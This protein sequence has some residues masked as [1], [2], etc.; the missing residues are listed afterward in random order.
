MI[1]F[2]KTIRQQLVMENKTSKYIKYA[3]GEIV[4][5]VIGIL[6]ALQINT[7]NDQRKQE[8]EEK[9]A[10][11]NIKQDFSYNKK[12]LQEV[13]TDTDEGIQSCLNV[14]KYTGNKP[15]PEREQYFDS[16]LNKVSI[17]PYYYPRNGFLDDLINSGKLSLF[18]NVDL[19]NRLSSWKPMVDRLQERYNEL[20]DYQHVMNDFIIEHGCWLNA[21]EVITIERSVQ[22]P[23]SGFDKDNRDLLGYI[24]FENLIENNAIY[25]DNYRGEIVN[26]RN[27]LDRILKLID[28]EMNTNQ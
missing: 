1:K 12:L 17:T 10:L 24:E 4:L 28:E 21:D 3:I 16:L 11:V 13:L 23:K 25:L 19:R 7:W 22:F 18:K 2:F 9:Q 14:L 5:V 6:I 27:L 26:T 8:N 15:K 20:N